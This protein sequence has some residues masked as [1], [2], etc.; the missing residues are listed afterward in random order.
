MGVFE[1]IIGLLGVFMLF[2]VVLSLA[3]YIYTSLA[4]MAIA[5]R[6]N[7]AHSWM[8]WIPFLN[9][10]LL[11]QIAGI[12]GIT[13]LVF[14]FLFIAPSFALPLFGAGLGMF[15]A[16]VLTLA[17]L[18]GWIYLFWKIAEECKRPGWWGIILVLVPFVNLILLGILAWGKD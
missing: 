6:T 18:I 8:A 3:V 1:T 9:I 13:T 4:L 5:K 7:T 2:F 14:V 11:T 15:I 16:L 12:P 17:S 10:Y